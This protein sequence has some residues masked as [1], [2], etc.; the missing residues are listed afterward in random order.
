MGYFT[1]AKRC[2]HKGHD[3]TTRSWRVPQDFCAIVL[4]VPNQKRILPIRKLSQP[5]QSFMR[6][7]AFVFVC[8]C[9]CV[10]VCVFGWVGGWGG[11]GM[12]QPKFSRSYLRRRASGHF[13]GFYNNF[14]DFTPFSVH[15]GAG[16][17]VRGNARVTLDS[18]PAQA[19]ESELCSVR[20]MQCL[21]SA[22]TTSFSHTFFVVRPHGTSELPADVL[23][24]AQ[25][26]TARVLVD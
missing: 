11:L 22:R 23:T 13:Q 17:T 10:F 1:K 24:T 5:K 9:V 2:T 8:V 20:G 26:L 4:T 7:P 15:S 19:S 21:H 16:R 14:D 6:M 25:Y 12:V 18:W 3:P